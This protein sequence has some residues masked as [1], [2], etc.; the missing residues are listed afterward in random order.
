MVS[1]T[2]IVKKRASLALVLCLLML[3]AWPVA[4]A[5]IYLD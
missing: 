1:V 2:N 4:A 5:D 3:A